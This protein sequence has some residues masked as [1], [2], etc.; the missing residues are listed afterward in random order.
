[1]GRE[2]TDA[3]IAMGE[4]HHRIAGACQVGQHVGVAGID[5][6]RQIEGLL[7]EAAQ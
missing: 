6:T 4:H 1:M 3:E 5:V 7:V 2:M